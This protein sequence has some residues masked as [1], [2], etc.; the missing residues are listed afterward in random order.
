MRKLVL[1][2]F[3][4]VLTACG[5]GAAPIDD[6]AAFGRSPAP[7]PSPPGL[8]S[9]APGETPEPP[10]SV[11]G[12][13]VVDPAVI[14]P[15]TSFLEQQT[16]IAQDQLRLLEG[17]AVEW[18]D[19]SLGCP[20]PDLAYT[21]VVVPGYKLSFTDGSRTYDIHTDDLG[22]QVILCEGGRPRN[23]GQP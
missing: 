7:L 22:G 9:P 5:Q 14:G 2:I 16:G 21:Q 3:V 20:E 4:A 10:G 23:L 13:Q 19:S 11:D 18:P 17:E 1:V 12:E 8:A 15:I 6:E